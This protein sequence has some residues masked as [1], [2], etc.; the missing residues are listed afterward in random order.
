MKEL[1]LPIIKGTMPP[2][3]RLSMNDYLIFVSLNLKY[4]V[5]QK[6]NR[7]Q[8]KLLAVNVSFSLKE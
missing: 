3:K 7:I 4:G 5:T 2:P 1:R 8:K 6:I